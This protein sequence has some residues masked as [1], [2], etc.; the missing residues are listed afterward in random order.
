MAQLK[1]TSS[2]A[3]KVENPPA[4]DFKAWQKRF[5]RLLLVGKP[6]WKALHKWLRREEYREEVLSKPEILIG[7]EIVKQERFPAGNAESRMTL[8]LNQLYSETRPPEQN[9]KKR[10]NQVLKALDSLATQAEAF[11][12]NLQTTGVWIEAEDC[13]SELDVTALLNIYN[14]AAKDSRYVLDLLR[15]E[16]VH[17]SDVLARCWGIIFYLQSTIGVTESHAVA[18]VRLALCAHGYDLDDLVLSHLSDHSVSAGTIRKR[19]AKKRQTVFAT[20]AQV[21]GA[22]GHSLRL[23]YERVPNAEQV[24]SARWPWRFRLRKK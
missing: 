4:V 19:I 6:A 2:Q 11:I 13:S 7:K 12:K 5:N 17:R 3:K 9:R 18:L 8:L 22:S 10:D 24:A 21:F 16:Y 14:T 20:M 15:R 23:D 1:K